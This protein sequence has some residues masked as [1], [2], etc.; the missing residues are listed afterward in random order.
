VGNPPVRR[1]KSSI[2]WAYCSPRKIS[3]ASRSRCTHVRHAGS[4][5]PSMIAMTLSATSSA[6]IA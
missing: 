5:I 4:A 1:E 6:A 2:A 3:S